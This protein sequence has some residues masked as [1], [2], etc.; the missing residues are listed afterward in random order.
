[1]TTLEV[2]WTL[3]FS[4]IVIVSVIGNCIVIWIV[5]GEGP[6]LHQFLTEFLLFSKLMWGPHSSDVSKM[7][8][9]GDI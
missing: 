1:M 5:C 7:I 6:F 3:A 8:G 4:L 2:V 9:T